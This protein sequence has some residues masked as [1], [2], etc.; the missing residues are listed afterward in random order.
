MLDGDEL[1][2]L[3][4]GAARADLSQHEI[5]I[6]LGGAARHNVANAL[7]AAALTW[8]LGTSLTIR[9]GLTTMEQDEN[10]GRCNIYDLNGI[11]VLI[12]FRPQPGG[13]GG[14]VRYGARHSGATSCAVFRTGR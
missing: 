11:K 6:A 12:D 2:K 8:C 10:P 3:E 7:S 1:L 13:Y 14:A 9:T 4:N 5:P